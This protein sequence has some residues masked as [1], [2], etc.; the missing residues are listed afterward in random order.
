V[1]KFIIRRVVWT[2]PVILL[3]VLMTFVLMR[4]IKGNPFQVTERA[5]PASIQR[6]LDR[7]YHLNKPWYVQYAYYVKGVFTFDLGPS[8]V[9]RN[10]TVNDVIKEHFPVSLKLGLFALLWAVVLGIPLGVLSA[11]KQNS[12]VDYVSMTFVNAGYA[13]PNFLVS[14]LLIY[15][16]ALRLR[17]Y[18]GF[19]T[20]GWVGWH[21]W[22]LPAIALGHAPLT[23]FARIVRGSMLE[24]LQQDYI[25]TARAK[26]L[27]YRRVVGL[28]VLRNS[29]IP[30]VTAAGPLLGYLITGAFLVEFIFGIP[31]IGRY[32]VISVTGRDY[33]VT[34][35]ITV[36]LSAIVIVANLAVDILYGY[37]DPRTRDA[38]T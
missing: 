36:M 34:M 9:Q 38:R 32:F 19:P 12:I 30:V 8:L 24:T 17:N 6:N 18:T 26:G 4:Q 25:R 11:L 31:G 20:N 35:G 1:L 14:T 29:L 27:R 23:V 33:S 15:F 5:V 37:L 22:I 21:S 2:I 7:K 3:V 13:L 10:Q 16:F 28:H